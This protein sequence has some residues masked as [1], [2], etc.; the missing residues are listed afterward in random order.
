MKDLPDNWCD[1]IDN[2]QGMLI[3]GYDREASYFSNAECM[4]NVVRKHDISLSI[5][6]RVSCD[7]DDVDTNSFTKVYVIDNKELI[8]S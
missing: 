6:G 5:I 2:E 1:E 4:L 3:Y 7:W 8:F